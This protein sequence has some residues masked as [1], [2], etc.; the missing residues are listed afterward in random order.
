MLKSEIADKLVAGLNVAITGGIDGDVIAVTG[1][2]SGVTILPSA[3]IAVVG[4][5]VDGY[6]ITATGNALV[7]GIG[8]NISGDTTDGFTIT[9]TGGVLTPSAGIA[10]TGDEDSGY[11]VTATGQVLLVNK[12][13]SHVAPKTGV[14]TVSGT[15]EIMIVDDMS[16]DEYFVKVSNA[17]VTGD[18]MFNV[19]LNDVKTASGTI[20]SGETSISM[21]VDP[22]DD[23]VFGDIIKFE[24]DPTND[25]LPSDVGNPTWFAFRSTPV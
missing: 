11:T 9:V 18:A 5:V 8:V 10:I 22:A 3:G 17:P 24:V 7:Q 12:R 15:H 13:P 1:L 2:V 20:V 21:P 23:V 25:T 4:D 14:L 19:Y 16:I 6:T